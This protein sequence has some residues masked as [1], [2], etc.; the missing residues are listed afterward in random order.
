M[1]TYELTDISDLRRHAAERLNN[2]P[3]LPNTTQLTDLEPT[4]RL[5][6][7]VMEREQRESTLVKLSNSLNQAG[8]GVFITD[9]HGCI[10]YANPT[11]CKITG[12][13]EDEAIGS[14]P[15]LFSRGAQSSEFY[16]I[17]W[18][19]VTSGKIW[20]D[21]I[22]NQRK[23]GSCYPAHLTVSPVKNSRGKIIK[24]IC[25]QSDLIK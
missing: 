12:Y 17:L 11:F 18:K 15:N 25:I 2:Q 5:A 8:E 1:K 6:G 3:A 24:F 10:E 7:I 19:T 9:T 23:D 16:A 20:A 14:T 21:E 13:P 4:A 22:I